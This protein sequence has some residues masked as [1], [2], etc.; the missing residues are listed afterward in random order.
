MT[1]S[2]AKSRRTQ[3]LSRWRVQTHRT[4]SFVILAWRMS[5]EQVDWATD[6]ARC[7]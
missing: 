3:R 5:A 6:H 2:G 7:F 4:M 1:S